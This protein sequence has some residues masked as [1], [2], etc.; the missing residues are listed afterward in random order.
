MESLLY[1]KKIPNLDVRDFFISINLCC[2]VE[3]I[4]AVG[5]DLDLYVVKA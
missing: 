3:S 1:T 5:Q 2:F 4:S